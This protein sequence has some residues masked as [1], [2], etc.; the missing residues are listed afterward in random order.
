MYGWEASIRQDYYSKHFSLWG[1]SKAIPKDGEII[2]IKT[3]R[4]VVVEETSMDDQ[5]N[6]L[7]L[8]EH[9]PIPPKQHL[10]DQERHCISTIFDEECGQALFE[11]L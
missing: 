3:A 1:T 2:K 11:M 10:S 8:G 5:C 9:L 4:G 7:L 6:R